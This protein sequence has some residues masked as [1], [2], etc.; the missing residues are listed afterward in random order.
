MGVED[1]DWVGRLRAMKAHTETLHADTLDAVATLENNIESR[2]GDVELV[3]DETHKRVGDL[4]EKVAAL[5]ALMLRQ[6]E[7]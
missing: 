5:H 2:I 6:V 1:E 7:E 3:A 4:A